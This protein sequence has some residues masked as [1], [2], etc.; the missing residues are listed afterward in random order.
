M[1]AG[2]IP[3]SSPLTRPYWDAA[4]Q[5]ELH[6]QRCAAC[7]ERP[8]PPRAHCPR[9]GGGTLEWAAMSGRATVYTFTV[10]RRPPHPVFAPRCPLVVAVIELEEGP[11]LISNVID[12]DPASMY[13]GMPVLVVFERIDDSDIMLPVFRPADAGARAFGGGERCCDSEEV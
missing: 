4:R 2:L 10:A 12:V 3:P 6:V 8:F 1:S 11:R 9:C 13:V 5:G 7:G